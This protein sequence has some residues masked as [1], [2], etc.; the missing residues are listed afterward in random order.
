MNSATTLSGYA[1]YPTAFDAR[2]SIGAVVRRNRRRSD[3]GGA[4]L[5][6]DLRIPVDDHLGEVREQLRCA[7]AAR[8]ELEQLRRLFQPARAHAARLE[9]GV[10]DD[11]FEERDI[12]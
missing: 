1:V 2:G 3:P 7:I 4:R 6:G 5:S 11:V 10:V 9:I 12:G 8:F